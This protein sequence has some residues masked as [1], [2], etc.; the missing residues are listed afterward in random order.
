MPTD[1]DVRA[2]CHE[3][4]ASVAGHASGTARA[5]LPSGG[6]RRRCPTSSAPRAPP[7]G[8]AG[9]PSPRRA[10]ACPGP[11]SRRDQ[12][13]VEHLRR[14]D[15]RDPLAVDRAPER[16]VRLLAV[17]PDADDREAVAPGRRERV[18]QPARRSPSRG[19][20]P[21]TRRRRL[22]AER[23]ER[24]RRRAERERL[25]ARR[26]AVR[27]RRL[28]VHDGQ[29]GLVRARARWEPAPSAGVGELRWRGLPRSGRRRRTRG[30]RACR[31]QRPAR[32]AAVSSP[33]PR[34]PGRRARSPTSPR[35]GEQPTTSASL[36]SRGIGAGM[37][38]ADPFRG[39][40]ARRW[41]RLGVRCARGSSSS[42]RSAS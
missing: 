33:M 38:G 42:S 31:C 40:I 9:R 17:E 12:V 27:D 20:S 28:E 36:A 25:R 2:G 29:V 8:A 24:G 3:L 32:R 13:V 6:R 19:C 23:R 26:A 10:P 1:D 37:T 41:S 35:R 16:P 5:R 18:A 34:R 21:S 30:R 4:L 22:L 15:D 39:T 14:A 11:R 7:A